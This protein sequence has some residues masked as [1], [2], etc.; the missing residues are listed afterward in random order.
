[1][2]SFRANVSAFSSFRLIPRIETYPTVVSFTQT[3]AGKTAILALFSL[4]LYFFQHDLP[5][6]LSLTIPL[7]LM[8]FMPEYR[9]FI[10]AVGPIIFLV[11][12]TTHDPL[13][14][15]STLTVIVLGIFLYWRA[16]RSPQSRFGKRPITFLLT[17]FTGLIL[18]ACA[19]TP[20]SWPYSVLWS[21]VG[22]MASYV[23]FIAYAVT[24]RNSKPARDLTL[25]VAALRPLWGS[26]NVPFPKG[27]AYLR[28]IEA[29]TP[30]QLAVVQLKGLKLL[31]WAIL[32]F[33]FQAGW[34]NFFHG[35]L[36]IPVPDQ[37]LTMSVR[38]TP[39]A[40]HLRWVSQILAFFEL[41]LTFSIGGHKIIA[42]C[43]MAGF[44]ALRNTYRPL[45]SITI[46]E[47]FNRFYYYFKEM[48]VDFFFYPV[49]LRYW[50]RHRRLRTIFAT[51][52]AAFFGNS[53]YHLIRD[54]QLI[55]DQGLWHSVA[56]YQVLFF[57]NATL[58]AGLCVSQLRKRGPRQAGIL[59][60]R[61]LPALGV[62]CFYCL[63]SV[64]DIDERMYPLAVHVK[65]LASLFFIH[66]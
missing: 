9:R 56:A 17:G 47:F 8:A 16:M 2:E 48:L 36:H 61:I 43:R 24:D 58:A 10:L 33:A 52:A 1:M 7:L 34:N 35:Y 23:W 64:F 39:L 66:Y 57:Y 30:E 55:R 5:E 20:S 45:S 41:I 22:A 50:K 21:L 38:G 37:A 44:N 13:L 29:L 12:R 25:E 19:A 32:L 26:P 4:G 3:A 60:G 54:W 14:L 42:C 63:L 28:R 11:L 27:A 15:G 18:L 51:F 49:F 59:R 40:W 65:Y 6:V 46:A 31:A 62:G 53:L